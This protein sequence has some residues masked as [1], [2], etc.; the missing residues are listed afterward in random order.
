MTVTTAQFTA[1]P[2][3][4]YSQGRGQLRTGDI[5]LFHSEGLG[6]HLIEH[7]TD[8]LWSHAAFIWNIEDIDRVLLLE[9]VDTFGVRALAFSNRVNGSSADPTPY[10]GKLLVARHRDFPHPADP[11]LVRRIT[12][13]AIDRLGYPYASHELVKIGL[14]IAAGLAGQTL[15]GTLEPQN[16]YVCSE[17]V[18]KCFAAMGIE[19]APDKEGFMAPADIANDPKVDAVLSLCPEPVRVEE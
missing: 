10:P 12:E 8:S 6:S 15:P 5:V 9:S 14:R 11:M 17:Y 1:M 16:A 2:R 13:F 3:T 7:F 19:L 4:P 18:A